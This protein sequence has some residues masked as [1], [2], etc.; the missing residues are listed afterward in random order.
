MIAIETESDQV[1]QYRSLSDR[2]EKDGVLVEYV[3]SET[4][5]EKASKV[6]SPA[7]DAKSDNLVERLL[8]DK[9]PAQRKKSN[10]NNTGSLDIALLQSYEE[11]DMR[12]DR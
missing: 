10:K 12:H 5:S 6:M 7:N 11:S 8:Q 9:V 3:T 4:T 1:A 2:S